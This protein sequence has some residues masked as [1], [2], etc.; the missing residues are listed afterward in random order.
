MR[1]VD[2]VAGNICQALTWS[3]ASMSELAVAA[4]SSERWCQRPRNAVEE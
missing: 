4:W 1:V 2:D 3:D